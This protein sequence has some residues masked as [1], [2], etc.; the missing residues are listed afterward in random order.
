VNASYENM[1]EA[2]LIKFLREGDEDAFLWLVQKYHNS[3]VRLALP[4]VQDKGLAEE[5][6]QETWI[7]ILNGLARFEGR[8]K[9]K[10]WIFTILINRAKTRGQREKRS[11]PF[12]EFDPFFEDEPTV[13]PA[14]FYPPDSQRSPGHWIVHPSS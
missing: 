5:V 14:R 1:D 8:A 4:Y 7:A 3:F 11:L 10:T 9:L 13:D 2:L 6:A 12:S